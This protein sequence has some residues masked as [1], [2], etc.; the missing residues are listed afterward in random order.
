[1]IYV[2]IITNIIDLIVKFLPGIITFIFQKYTNTVTQN[3]TNMTTDILDNKIKS[4]TGLVIM[5]ILVND[6]TNI[7]SQAI[8]YYKSS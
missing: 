3:I 7:T 2:M 4:K 6:A 5:D 1:M 8:L